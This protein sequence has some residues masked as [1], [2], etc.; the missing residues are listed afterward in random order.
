MTSIGFIRE[1]KKIPGHMVPWGKYPT[2]IRSQKPNPVAGVN[3]SASVAS[4]Y[5]VWF[6]GGHSES[7]LTRLHAKTCDATKRKP[8]ALAATRVFRRVLRKSFSRA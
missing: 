3:A 1:A 8:P 6:S 5:E 4:E 7:V 2:W